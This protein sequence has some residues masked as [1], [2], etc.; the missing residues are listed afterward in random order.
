MLAINEVLQ[1]GRYRITHQFGQDGIGAGYEAYDNV[2]ESNVVVKELNKT[3][4]VSKQEMS[5]PDFASE[6][7]I[8]AEIKHDSILHV[9]DYF[10]ETDRQFLVMESVDGNDLGELLEKNAGAFALSD[11]TDWADQLLDALNSLHTHAPPIFHR[12]IKPQ[13]LKMTSGGKIKLLA[14]GI[15]NNSDAAGKNQTFDAATLSYLP[16]EQIWEGLDPA[17]QKVITNSYDERS[18]KIL[19]QPADARSD[20]YALG[21]TLYHLLTARLPVDALERSIEILDGKPDPLPNPNQI[22]PLVPV[23]ISD[24]LVKAMELKRENRFDSAVI[25]RHVLR[26]ALRRV[27]E[28]E[29][30]EAKKQEESAQQIRLAKQERL[31]QERQNAEQMKQRIEQE[32]KAEVI[33]LQLHE[34]EKLKAGQ[35]AAEAE[36]QSFELEIQDLLTED[37]VPAILKSSEKPAQTFNQAVEVQ[38]EPIKQIA[39]PTSAPAEVKE[40]FAEPETDKK[41]WWK[42]PAIAF[43]LLILVGAGFGIWFSQ[44]PK[45]IEPSQAIAEPKNSSAEEAKPETAPETGAIPT[46]SAS[47]EITENPAGQSAVKTKS[48]QSAMPAPKVEKRAAP[49]VKTQP[50]VKK[51]VTVDDII[52][53]N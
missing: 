5:Q 18:E 13:N 21:A 31:E 17:S 14:F 41:V 27:K 43:V 20:I 19:R 23:E 24:V 3:S 32:Q 45:T 40:L 29:V 51:A 48:V 38:P 33:E 9:H 50:K 26:T 15:S 37:S 30:D 39:A 1:K 6:A 52:N 36:R 22:N 11:V 12:D 16:L 8:L 53:D 44:S 28:R 2:L 4:S 46:V 35:L 10:S 47:P 49:P 25:M 42:I 34:D 7:K